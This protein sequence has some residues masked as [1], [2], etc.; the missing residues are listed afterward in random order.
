MNE[1][2]FKQNLGQF[3]E[4]ED[5]KKYTTIGL[6]G[7]ARFVVVAKDLRQ[8]VNIITQA[9]NFGIN[10][11]VL[12]NGSNLLISDKGFDGLVIINRT[13]SIQI[14]KTKGIVIAEG[15]AALS[16]LILD[17]AALG[18]SGLEALFGIPGS[19]AGAVCVNAGA[20]QIS[21]G[22]FLRSSTVMLSSEK[23]VSVQRDWFNFNYRES[24]LKYKKEEFPPVILTAIFQ[25]QQKRKEDILSEI[26][27]FKKIREKNQPLGE[28]TCGSIFKNPSGTDK[29]D[30]SKERTA[31]YL[32][33]SA[34]AKKLKNGGMRVSKKHANW[35]I[36]EGN[37]SSY[38]ARQLIEKMRQIVFDKYSLSLEEEI[39]YFGDWT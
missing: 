5:L 4:F 22:A 37:A 9:R 29:N 21:T 32:L 24:R 14:D 30:E 27:K 28:K 34:G 3:E 2:K 8:L 6:G 12:G 39:E 33:D 20:H 7:P 11:K 19:V 18:L 25:F 36:N 13:N 31:G 17:S 10:Y 35:I 1:S 15:G 26:S 16:K 38:Q 23:V